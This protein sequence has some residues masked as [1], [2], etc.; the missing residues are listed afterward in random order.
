[1]RR[2]ELAT[3]LATA[4]VSISS[5]C[6]FFGIEDEIGSNDDLEIIN[7]A[8]NSV[9]LNVLIRY[10]RLGTTPDPIFEEQIEVK[11]N[12]ERVLEVLG[13]NSYRIIVNGPRDTLSFKSS[14][15][16]D[17]ARTAII[18]TQNKKLMSEVQICE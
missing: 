18:I 13:D 2:R 11:G 1:M 6:V 12:S 10:E 14:P 7:R 16:C 8:D 9:V 3:M 15:Q 4:S 5:G 17:H